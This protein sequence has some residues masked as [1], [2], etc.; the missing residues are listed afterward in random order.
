MISGIFITKNKIINN[1]LGNI[2]HVIKSS[3][4]GYCGFG[5]VYIS[6]INKNKIKGWKRHNKVTINLTVIEGRVKFAI[7]DDRKNSKTFGEI[8][9]FI[10]GPDLEFSRLTI[11]HGLWVA[12][13][14]YEDKNLIINVIPEEHNELEADNRSLDLIEFPNL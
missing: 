3:S 1:P 2:F 7:Y 14:G 11:S 4:I 12:F 9:T 5:E 10:L 8:N 6:S 13:K